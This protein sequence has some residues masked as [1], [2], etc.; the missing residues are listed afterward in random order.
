MAYKLLARKYI[1]MRNVLEEE[2]TKLL[3]DNERDETLNLYDY[4]K[5][6]IQVKDLIKD[7]KSMDREFKNALADS[8]LLH[9]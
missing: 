3:L 5:I 8:H 2:I 7:F 4:C 6:E 9:C 1:P